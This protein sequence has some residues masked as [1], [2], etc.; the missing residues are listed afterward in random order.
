MK[1]ND[2]RLNAKTLVSMNFVDGNLYQ[3]YCVAGNLYSFVNGELQAW[4]ELTY[5]I[6]MNNVTILFA[7]LATGFIA[8]TECFNPED[9][10]LFVLAM[11]V[12]VPTIIVS[13]VGICIGKNF[14]EC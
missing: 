1:Y 9:M 4:T 6:V 7:A 13:A 12:I 8:F 10:A 2:T 5:N 11:F 14:F 3:T